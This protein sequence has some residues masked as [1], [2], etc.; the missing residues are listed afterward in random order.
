VGTVENRLKKEDLPWLSSLV[1]AGVAGWE[2]TK[3]KAAG[4]AAVFGLRKKGTAAGLL[5]FFFYGGE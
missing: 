4:A 5:F 3:K 2:K 1:K